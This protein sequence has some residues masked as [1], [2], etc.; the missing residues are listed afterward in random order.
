MS[1]LGRT[2]RSRL[3]LRGFS[4]SVIV[5]G[6]LAL[7]AGPAAARAASIVSSN[8]AGYVAHRP[9]VSFRTVAATWK[10]PRPACGTPFPGYSSTWVG[11]G[12]FRSATSAL[13]QV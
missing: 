1:G 11:L 13:E 6:L 5:A 9:G 2:T 10:E 12:G 4:K 3:R 8:W 7:A